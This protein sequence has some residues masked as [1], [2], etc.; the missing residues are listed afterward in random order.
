MNEDINIENLMKLAATGEPDTDP[1]YK[2]TFNKILSGKKFVWNWSA[3][4]FGPL[5][6]IYR[7]AYG[8]SLLISVGGRFFGFLSIFSTIFF[9][10]LLGFVGNRFYLWSLKRKI[11]RG[12]HRANLNNTDSWSIIFPP[13]ILFVVFNDRRKVRMALKNDLGATQ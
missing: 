10:L 2:D 13:C 9:M 1:Y 6:L 8:I 7:K 11:R 4:F 5:W 12:F 3:F